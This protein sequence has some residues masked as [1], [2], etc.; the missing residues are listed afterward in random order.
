MSAP[1]SPTPAPP[2]PEPFRPRPATLGRRTTKVT[3]A[4]NSQSQRPSRSRSRFRPWR[5]R[6]R[7]GRR[8]SPKREAAGRDAH[9]VVPH[10]ER[11][12]RERRHAARRLFDK[13][14]L[15]RQHWLELGGHPE[16][17]TKH[18][19]FDPQQLNHRQPG[20]RAQARAW[21]CADRKSNRLR[22]R[23]L[24]AHLGNGDDR[25]DR[26]APGTRPALP[27]RRGD[28]DLVNSEPPPVVERIAE[29]GWS[30]A[31]WSG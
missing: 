11:L 26:V 12:K 28:R 24:R 21:H 6:S 2:A 1:S 16:L 18:D 23:R 29:P 13:L 10:G 25:P 20:R 8:T 4:S 7:P 30:T 17:R 31:N 22:A 27:Q 14:G 3:S 19:C 15:I 9:D 5:S